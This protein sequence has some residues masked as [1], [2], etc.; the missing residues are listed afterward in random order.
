MKKYLAQRDDLQAGRAPRS[1]SD[2]FNVRDLVNRF[3]TA[4][5]HVVDTNELTQRTFKDYFS[6]CELLVTHLG[7][8]RL[9]CDLR[10]DDF[11]KL[12][13]EF[14]K[15]RGLVALGNLVRMSRIVFKYAF[16][17]DLIE[18]PVKFGP[19]FKLPSRKA[20][21]VARNSKPLRMFE[22]A[23]IRKILDAADQPLKTMI[24]LG[25]RHIPDQNRIHLRRWWPHD[26]PQDHGKR[27]GQ[28][29]HGIQF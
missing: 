22:A 18:R 19:G 10:T 3:L 28:A 9:V 1:S 5:Q 15:T 4:K 17:A 27:D 13:V 26:L 8:S 25:S 2:G 11:E 12:R 14:A 16:D 20:L 29:E 21:R 23:E 6:T 24:L 7:K